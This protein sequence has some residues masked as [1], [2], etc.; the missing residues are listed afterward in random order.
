MEGCFA[1]G[2]FLNCSAVHEGVAQ[3]L[4]KLHE[5]VIQIAPLGWSKSSFAL[6]KDRPN[7]L[8]VLG[9]NGLVELFLYQAHGH[10]Q[11]D[12]S[13]WWQEFQNLELG[14]PRLDVSE[15]LSRRRSNFTSRKMV[16]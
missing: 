8:W 1:N 2:S 11:N 7:K 3:T 9:E 15:D 16:E 13:H 14:S 10:W 4:T 5:D 6:P 12:L